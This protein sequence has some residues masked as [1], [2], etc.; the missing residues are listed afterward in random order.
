MFRT[1]G[2]S[3][4]YIL[5]VFILAGC[6]SSVTGHRLEEPNPPIRNLRLVNYG[7]TIDNPGYRIQIEAEDLLT[8]LSKRIPVIFA[9]NGI[10]TGQCSDAQYDLVLKPDHWEI[11]NTNSESWRNLHVSASVLDKAQSSKKIWDGELII[12][13]SSTSTI[14]DELIDKLANEL[15]QKLTQDKVL[16]LQANRSIILADK[17]CG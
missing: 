1:I 14:N 17:R 16:E 2:Q 8:N 12:L 11:V 15:M 7:V 10:E 3:V 5:L 6:V 4:I 13:I 9:L